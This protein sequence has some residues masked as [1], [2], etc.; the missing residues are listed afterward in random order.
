ME[1]LLHEQCSNMISCKLL[2]AENRDR[3][4]LWWNA[5]TIFWLENETV[6][7]YWPPAG[8]LYSL[9]GDLTLWNVKELVTFFFFVSLSLSLSLERHIP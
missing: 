3:G 8:W 7:V 2:L 9:L 5:I 4:S 1:M 6:C